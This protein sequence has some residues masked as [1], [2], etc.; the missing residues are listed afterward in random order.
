MDGLFAAMR[1]LTLGSTALRMALAV[2]FGGAIGLDREYKRHPAGFRTYMLVCLG[3][4]T[5]VMLGQYEYMMVTTRWA[6]TSKLVGLSTDVSRFGA[7]V[8]NGIGFLSAGTILVTSR[9]EVYGM[10]TA[11]CLWASACMGLAIGAGYYECTIIGFAFIILAVK[12]LPGVENKILLNSRN[13][14]F[15]VECGSMADL[16][17]IIDCIRRHNAVINTIEPET[18]RTNDAGVAF[19]ISVRMPRKYVRFK[20]MSELTAMKC[21]DGIEEV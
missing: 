7:Q 20:L 12:V 14:T 19:I 11:A 13:I 16:Q 10:T 9:N 8:I 2:I 21:V 6:E 18:N 5:A 1:E 3:A 4:A 15:C 17:E